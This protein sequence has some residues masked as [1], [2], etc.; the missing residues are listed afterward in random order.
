MKFTDIKTADEYIDLVGKYSWLV[1]S[2]LQKLEANVR[3][4]PEQIN[5]ESLPKLISMINVIG[6]LRGQDGAFLDSRPEGVSEYQSELYKNED[7]FENRL[8]NIIK[9]ICA[10]PKNLEDYKAILGRYFINARIPN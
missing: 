1:N 2:E 6:Y 8:N 3:E 10:N 5:M 4:H 9:T 7:A